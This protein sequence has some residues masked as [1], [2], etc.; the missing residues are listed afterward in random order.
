MP[1]SA[2]Q[3]VHV[4][5]A[6]LHT[7]VELVSTQLLL[8]KHCTH[9]FVVVLQTG[10]GPVHRTE[11]ARSHWTH[12]PVASR[13]AGSAVVGH[14]F[15]L[16][17]PLSPSQGTHECVAEH[18]GLSGFVQLADVRH[19]MH[20]L[21]V[22]SQNGF[23]GS[24]QSGSLRQ[25][26]HTPF[27]QTGVVPPQSPF[28]VQSAAQTWLLQF[29]VSG[30]LAQSAFTLHCT[31]TLLVVSQTGLPG[32]RAH[33]VESLALHCS[34]VPGPVGEGTQA[35]SVVVGQAEVAPE[36]WLPLHF[37]HC[38]FVQTGVEPGQVEL[39]RQF[40]Q[41]WF[42]TSHFVLFGSLLHCASVEQ[43][44]H[45]PLGRQDGFAAVHGNL[46]VGPGSEPK[47]PE[48]PTHLFVSMSHEP[49]FGMR[50]HAVELVALHSRHAPST[51]AGLAWVGHASG[52]PEPK[53]P[54]HEVQPLL[55]HT[56]RPCGQSAEVLQAWQA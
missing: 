17:P 56:G 20:W 4:F 31:H 12:W 22:V 47:S 15:W 43:S 51:Q 46:F 2:L 18:T 6:V 52:L 10:V 44:T 25:P 24:L 30:V 16:E 38:L 41:T 11:L 34:H 21:I 54:T 33:A 32:M 23:V 13:Q 1:L 27:L 53:S 8:F 14:A 28:V 3:P 29:G 37:T 40:T 26:T 45:W 19:S 39:S 7:G 49:L 42:G 36:L 50:A 9:E 48:H 35:G 5:V 55:M